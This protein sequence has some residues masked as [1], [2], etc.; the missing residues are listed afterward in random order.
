MTLPFFSYP[1]TMTT[2][3]TLVNGQAISYRTKGGGLTAL[4]LPLALLDVAL[5]ARASACTHGVT[6][7]TV[8][9]DGCQGFG[10][11]GVAMDG[12]VALNGR[13]GEARKDTVTTL[14]GV[15]IRVELEVPQGIA[16]IHQL[17]RTHVAKEWIL[18]RDGCILEM[19]LCVL[20][21][22][23]C[24]PKAHVAHLAHL[25]RG[26]FDFVLLLHMLIHFP[27]A[28]CFEEALV[29][30]EELPTVVYLH[31]NLHLLFP[32]QV[33]TLRTLRCGADITQDLL[34][35]TAKMDFP[36]MYGQFILIIRL[37]LAQVTR[38]LEDNWL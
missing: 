23:F 6:L 34:D 16:S 29:A 10:F 3:L 37:I 30:V 32:S 27:L 9:S 11:A 33:T 36:K 22:I 25:G 13:L 21:Q 19:H 7:P 4:A 38:M 18:D 35:L 12:E 2:K 26:Q 28:A 1:K 20:L 15:A 14:E 17:Q 24:V 8:L 5:T 31:M